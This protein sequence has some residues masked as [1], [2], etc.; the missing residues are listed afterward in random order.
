VDQVNGTDTEQSVPV[1]SGR[2]ITAGAAFSA[3]GD[4]AHRSKTRAEFFTQ[5]L[6]IIG[7]A[8]QSPYACLYVQAD[9]QLIQE[10]HHAGGTD[11]AFWRAAV[12]GYLTEGLDAARP[13]ARLLSA[14]HAPLRI[15][16][17]YAPLAA[18]ADDPIGGLAL[19]VPIQDRDIQQC[20]HFLDALTAFLMQVIQYVG[21]A[22]ASGSTEEKAPAATIAQAAGFESPEQLAFS[23]TNSLR[24]R[25]G[26]EQVALAAVRSRRCRLLSISG[27]DEIKTRSP[28]VKLIHAAM[29][30]CVDLGRKAGCQA[31]DHDGEGPIDTPIIH[32]QWHQSARG[33]AVLSVPFLDSD[34]HGAVLSL[35]RSAL[36]PFHREEIDRIE[37]SIKP[38]VPAFGLI[39]EAKRGLLAHASD[40]ARGTLNRLVR[41]GHA[42]T[43]LMILAVGV[44]S[45]WAAFGMIG[46][47]LTLPCK[48]ALGHARQVAA[49]FDAVIAKV[50]VRPGDFVAA[51]QV[52][53]TLDTRDLELEK[54]ELSAQLE[55]HQRERLKALADGPP[56]EARLAEASIR[57]IQAK[58]EVVERRIAQTSLR[59]PIDGLIVQGELESRVTGVVQHGE[60]LF[61]IAD[62]SEWMLELEAPEWA[63]PEISQ[64]LIGRFACHARPEQSSHMVVGR[65]R[66]ISEV[67]DGQNIYVVEAGFGSAASWIRPGMEGVA[68]VDLGKRRVWWVATFRVI[69]YLRLHFWL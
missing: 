14:R 41:P 4:A 23:L 3:L 54:R 61:Q 35:R 30:E 22:P 8:F 17:L 53:C 56:I 42:G 64:G 13:R 39:R 59:S 7:R 36:D 37:A 20:M 67:R 49:P 24:N 65:C 66:P 58:L 33:A 47:H 55:I 5:G 63:V 9:S 10:H 45:A 40:S 15:A 46:F 38:F 25:L 62:P 1:G 6:A 60:P 50:Y 69:D 12:E 51:G 19:V 29:E 32:R 2:A 16:L 28:G 48:V 34:G 21:V 26:C 68:R 18:Q 57:G 43:K 31:S 52:L 11:P 44:F 27:L